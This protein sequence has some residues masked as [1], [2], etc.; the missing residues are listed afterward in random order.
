MFIKKWSNGHTVQLYQS[1]TGHVSKKLF[2]MMLPSTCQTTGK[3]HQKK[4]FLCLHV[5][6]KWLHITEIK[7]ERVKTVT[8]N[9]VYLVTSNIDS[10][11]LVE[12]SRLGG[13]FEPPSL[14][15]Y[16]SNARFSRS[17]FE[18]KE[19]KAWRSLQTT[20]VGYLWFFFKHLMDIMKIILSGLRWKS[21]YQRFS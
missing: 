1:C 20:F 17:I 8:K 6:S 15:P 5:S 10:S 14:R 16:S 7:F 4:M 19:K 18:R 2:S 21:V 3:K 12:S 13:T 9:N 11:F